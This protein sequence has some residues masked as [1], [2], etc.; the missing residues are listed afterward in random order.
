MSGWLSFEFLL[1]GCGGGEPNAPNSNTLESTNPS[2][3]NSLPEIILQPASQIAIEG[4]TVTF[5]VVAI[6][7]ALSYQWQENGLDIGGANDASYTTPPLVVENISPV[8]TV[9]VS[10]GIGSIVSDPANVI[11]KALAL[12]TDN[13]IVTADSVSIS[14][15]EV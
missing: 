12:T 8:Y 2:S 14:V 11:V 13:L 10:N 5:S 4:E 15:D 1:Y 6:G 3:A 7:D 9:E